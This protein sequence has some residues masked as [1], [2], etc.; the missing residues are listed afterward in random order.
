ME[1][2]EKAQES[3]VSEDEPKYSNNYEPQISQY[4]LKTLK[5]PLTKY[6]REKVRCIEGYEIVQGALDYNAYL[7]KNLV[8]NKRKRKILDKSQ[9]HYV[10]EELELNIK[11]LA[12]LADESL[13]IREYTFAEN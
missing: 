6:L 12:M 4:Y 2:A 7:I 9:K 1:A 10:M 3:D 8:L 13:A 5:T 11:K